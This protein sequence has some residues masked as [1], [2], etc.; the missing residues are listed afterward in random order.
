MGADMKANASGVAAHSRFV[1]FVVLRM[2]ASA[3]APSS[4]MLLFPR[5]QA[6]GRV[7]TL[8]EQ[9]CQRALTRKQSLRGRQR[10]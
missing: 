5:L 1:I 6:R 2:A 3:A 9:V 7:A 8:R 4:P 10:T